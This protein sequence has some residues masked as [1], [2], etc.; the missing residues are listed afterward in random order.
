MSIGK[1][2]VATTFSDLA[3]TFCNSVLGMCLA[4]KRIDIVLDRSTQVSIKLEQEADGSKA[5][6]VEDRDVALPLN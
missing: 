4:Y 2:D 5:Y 1:P 3:D 6:L